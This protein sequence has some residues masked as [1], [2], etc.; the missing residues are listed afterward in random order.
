P[1]QTSLVQSL[2]SGV[3]GPEMLLDWHTPLPLQVSAASHSPLVGEPQVAPA[4]LFG[5][6]QAPPAQTSLVQSLLSGVHGPEMLLDWHTPLPLQVSAAS[7]SPLAG[8]PQIA[9][10]AL[11]GALPASP[12]QTSLVQSLLSGVHGPE[13]LLD[14]HTPLPLQVS[15]AS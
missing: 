3:H 2:V 14:W 8:E 12:A 4:D 1:A 15:A 9:P 13:M 10:L 11:L 5:W 6:V 7:P